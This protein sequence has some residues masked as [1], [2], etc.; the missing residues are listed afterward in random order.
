MPPSS[1]LA[2]PAVPP[3]LNVVGPGRVGQTLARLFHTAGVFRVQQVFGRDPARTRAACAFI[4]AGQASCDL[5]D[6]RHSAA[7]LLSVPDTQLAAVAAMVASV[8][9]IATPPSAPPLAFHCSGFLSASV[10]SPLAEH[11]WHTASV[12]P[13]YSFASPAAA[14]A[15]FAGTPCG[16]EGGIETTERLRQAFG[17]IGGVC[18][19]V[20][21]QRKPL[22]HAGAVFATNFL[23]VAQA[24][25]RDA[26]LAAGV[27][28]ALVP[29]LADALL[30]N[31]LANL[32]ALGPERALTGP[33]ARGDQA[34]VDAQA[35]V[36]TQWHA[37]AGDA[38]RALST[39]AAQ[40][41]RRRDLP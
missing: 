10:L 7:W 37:E 38:Y 33:A 1:T 16:V 21:S 14:V 41:A 19:E 13:V 22:Y 6:A 2:S 15:G 27:A 28:P 24:V 31:T 29:R 9:T 5:A 40:I 30:D 32:R 39:L 18:F 34:V 4:G 17:A 12:H 23:V 26:W 3:T 36:V 11:G 8:T 25:A 20:D 35:K